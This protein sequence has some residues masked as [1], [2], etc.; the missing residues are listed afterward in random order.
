MANKL[1][2]HFSNHTGVDCLGDGSDVPLHT[3]IFEFASIKEEEVLKELS[4]LKV[5][6][7]TGID[8]ISARMLKLSALAISNGLCSIF[9][10]ARLA[11]SRVPA[12]WKS[13]RIVPIPKQGGAKNVDNFHP[14]S[15]LLIVAKVFESLAFHKSTY[16]WLRKVFL[17]KFN[18]VSELGIAHKMFF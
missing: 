11:F 12:E 1:N 7:A 5:S 8:E 17:M 16:S 3:E 9:F 4:R 10:N 18:W 6:K 2:K 14:I 15:I 13:A